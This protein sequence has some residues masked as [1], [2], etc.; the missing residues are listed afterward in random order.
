VQS[1]ALSAIDLHHPATFQSRG[2]TVPFTTPL[3]AGGR[4]RQSERTGIELLVPNSSGGR[5]VY[6]LH[7]PGALELCNPTVHDRVLVEHLS[8]LSRI[9]PASVRNAALEIA[10]EG[11]AGREAGA[12]AKAALDS[13]HSRLLL[14]RF[15]LLADLV[16][17]AEP[18]GRKVTSLAER[19][20]AFERQAS[21]VLERIAPALGCPTAHL[22]ASL[23]AMGTAFAP[24]GAER[25][26]RTARIPRLITRLAEA[27]DDFLRWLP[28]ASQNEMASLGRT[29]TETMRVA[30]E[31]AEV[32]LAETRTSLTDPLELLK[33]WIENPDKAMDLASRCDWLLDGWEHICLL[34]KMAGS[35]GA[36][37]V[38]LLEMTQLLPVWPREV[39]DWLPIE[40]RSG[41]MD[42]ACRVT[43]RIDTWRSGAAALAMVQ[44]NERL[45]AMTT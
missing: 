37:R 34:W 6:I 29:L 21:L 8:H 45:R 3:L 36:R 9:D 12:A 2:V 26:D 11:Y 41:A 17:Q 39:T 14:T 44:R 42:P 22:T 32:I 10:L 25:D 38:A 33:R 7:W 40:I 27:R 5:G 28:P 4:V 24:I 18:A 31:G 43:S 19:T 16:E 1:A 30:F 13:D 15:L 35:E 20:P 23:T